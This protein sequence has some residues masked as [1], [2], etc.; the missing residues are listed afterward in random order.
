MSVDIG[1][2]GIRCARQACHLER[3]LHESKTFSNETS[4]KQITSRLNTVKTEL[5][6]FF[7]WFLV[8]K[9]IGQ[10]VN[11][12]LIPSYTE[13]KGETC[14]R[15]SYDKKTCYLHRLCDLNKSAFGFLAL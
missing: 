12:Q 9:F 13:Q 4:S 6:Y 11:C 14:L 2:F 15:Y 5:K 3:G 1:L 8:Y 10:H 7:S